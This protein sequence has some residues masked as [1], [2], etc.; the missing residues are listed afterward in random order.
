MN[1]NFKILNR[2]I[3]IFHRGLGIERILVSLIT[4]FNDAGNLVLVMGT[5]P[6]EEEYLLAQ[7][8]SHHLT[9]TP[10]CI[11]A[12]YPTTERSVVANTVS[13]DVFICFR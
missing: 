4:T 1:F 3:L 9:P 5:T 2:L 12:D 6:R 8:E 10:R 13:C 11:T 7:L